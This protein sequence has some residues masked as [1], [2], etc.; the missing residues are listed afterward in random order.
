MAVCPVCN[1]EEVIYTTSAR[2]KVEGRPTALCPHAEAHARAGFSP[3]PVTFF[4]DTGEATQTLAMAPF[5]SIYHAGVPM[6]VQEDGRCFSGHFLDEFAGVRGL[7]RRVVDLLVADSTLKPHLPSPKLMAESEAEG[8]PFLMAPLYAGGGMVGLEL[9][10][11]CRESAQRPGDSNRIGSTRSTRTIGERGVYLTDAFCSPRAVV[12]FEG[13]WDAISARWDAFDNQNGEF[14]FAGMTANTSAKTVSQALRRYFPGIPIIV[15]GDRDRPGVQAMARL[16]KLFPAA[17]LQGLNDPDGK[18]PKDYRAADPAKR[19]PALLSAVEEGL[20]EWERRKLGGD[21]DGRREVVIGSQESEIITA[22]M[23]ALAERGGVYLYGHQMVTVQDFRPARGIAGGTASGERP[24]IHEVS[25]LWLRE[26]VSSVVR[27]MKVSPEGQARE[28]LVPE[29]VSPMLMVSNRLNLLPVLKAFVEVPVLLPDGRVLEAPGYDEASGLFF[30]PIRH[31]PPMPD[32]PDRDDAI[33]AAE[34]LCAL[35]SDFP[36]GGASNQATHRAAWMA[37]L[38]TGFARFAIQGPVPLVLVESNGPASGKGL[39][40]QLTA[41]I[42]TGR[43]IPVCVA[44]QEGEEFSKMALALL[45]SGH[46]LVLLDEAPSPF[47]GRQLNALLTAYPNYQGRLLGQSVTLQ[48]P[49]LATWVATGNNLVLAPDLP[50]RCL[51]IRIEPQEERPEDREGFQF[52]DLLHHVRTHQPE[53]ARDVLTILRA[54]HLAGRPGSGLT[55][56]GS[57]EAWSDLV[58][59]AVYWVLGVDCDTRQ[60][61]AE[62]TDFTRRAQAVLLQSLQSEFGKMPFTTEQVL[63]LHTAGLAKHEPLI[64]ALNE[65]NKNPKGLCSRSLGHILLRNLRLPKDGWCLDQQEGTRGGCRVW[66]IRQQ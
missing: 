4:A 54:F 35:V 52:P 63:S 59:N 33:V 9:R 5:E 66:V 14:V 15:V 50:R 2:Y 7:S 39:L 25:G 31:F 17:V 24:C 27:L 37:F 26:H 65:L 62:R 20:E 11:F 47:G 46:R 55:Q 8:W 6:S 56:W 3:R 60:G 57:F 23:Q 36:F 45:R 34:R 29:W 12:L 64:E 61:L 51:H 40:V 48:V 41:E 18:G 58:R 53:L 16:R 19:W 21:P 44:P 32:A 28:T 43:S 22:T 42:Q 1:S 38:L 49:Q 30:A 13:T 10:Y